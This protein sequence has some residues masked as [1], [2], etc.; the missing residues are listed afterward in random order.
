MR[1]VVEYRFGGCVLQHVLYNKFRNE[2]S[3]VSHEGIRPTLTC[4]LAFHNSTHIRVY[5][6]SYTSQSA[7][8][9]N[10][11]KYVQSQQEKG[12]LLR[13]NRDDVGAAAAR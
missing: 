7:R 4:V 12:Q 5:M 6:L 11:Y 9:S 10:K 2:F 13:N 1:D 3:A 8:Q